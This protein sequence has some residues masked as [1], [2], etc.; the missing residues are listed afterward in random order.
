MCIQSS[1]HEHYKS[2]HLYNNQKSAV[3]TPINL[4]PFLFCEMGFFMLTRNM[5][6]IVKGDK[7]YIMVKFKGMII[8]LDKKGTKGNV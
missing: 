4:I 2:T 8:A 6:S 5:L 3:K 7:A 1:H